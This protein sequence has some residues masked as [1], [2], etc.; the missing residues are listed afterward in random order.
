MISEVIKNT[1]VNK[2]FN[3][4]LMDDESVRKRSVYVPDD[5]KDAIRDW[6]KEMM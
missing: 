5:I 6:V 4:P 2:P 3:T 1:N